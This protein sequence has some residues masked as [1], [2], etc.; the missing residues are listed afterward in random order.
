VR[1]VGVEYDLEIANKAQA[2]VDERCLQDRVSRSS[3]SL[4]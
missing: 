3:S 2:S 1:G 4:V